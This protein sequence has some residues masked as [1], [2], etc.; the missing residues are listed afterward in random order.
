MEHCNKG[1]NSMSQTVDAE[2]EAKSIPTDGGSN[3]PSKEP[4]VIFTWLLTT[5]FN[6]V[7]APVLGVIITFVVAGVLINQ[8]SSNQPASADAQGL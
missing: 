7:I 6:V 3:P 4:S 5:L 2:V 1:D 8:N